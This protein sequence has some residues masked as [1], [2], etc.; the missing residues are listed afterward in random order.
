MSLQND[1]ILPWKYPST[2]KWKEQLI[3]FAKKNKI[4]IEKKY[5]ELTIDEKKLIWTGHKNYKGINDFFKMVE[6]KSYKIQYRVM[7]SRYRG[8]TICPNCKGGRLKK[9]SENIKFKKFNI[10]DFCKMS[11]SELKL[12]FQKIKLDENE[13]KIANKVFAEIKLRLNLLSDLGLEY[14]TLNRKSS[15]LSGE[16]HKGLI[17]PNLLE[18][19]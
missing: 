14:L 7:L 2:I 13:D 17:L 6:S 12:F 3:S 8:R 15:T 16:K 4:S 19:D 1:A 5:S 11:I 18:G 10:Q 9:E